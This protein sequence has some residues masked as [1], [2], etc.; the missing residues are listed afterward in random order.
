VSLS[1]LRCVVAALILASCAATLNGQSATTGALEGAVKDAAGAAVPNATV[2]LLNRAT[3][4][5]HTAVSDANGAFRFS[6]LPPATYQVSF[7]A[8]GFKTSLMKEL[9]VNV[10]EVPVLDA[11][12]E[13]GDASES[14]ACRCRL[15]AAAT[16]TGTLVDQKTITSVPLN[17]RNFTQVLSM[18]SG[19]AADVNNA[20]TLGRGT[21]SVFVNGN[22]TA[23]A[24]TIDG[25]YA[26]ST[27]PNPDTIAEFKIQTSQYDAMYGAMAPSTNLLTKRGENDWHGD[28][29][30]F[31]RNDAFNANEFFRKTTGQPK[32]NLKQNQFG[33]TLGSAVKKNKLFVF[34]S[35]QGT[36]QVNGLDPTSTSNLILPALGSDRSAS[37]LAA[38]F[39]PAN[40]ATTG[41][42][43]DSRYITFAGGKQ[44]DCLNRSTETTAPINP[45]ALSILQAKRGDGAY[46]IPS[47][48]TIIA[49]GANAGL[50]F[51]S[52][53]LPSTYRENH[54]IANPDYVMSSKHTLS[55]R[56]FGATIHQLRSFGSSNGYPGAP[57]VPGWGASQ[58]LEATDIATSIRLTTTLTANVVNEAAM[59][60]TRN[61]TDTVGVD[62]PDAASFGMTAVD[63]LFP[64]TPE[65]TVLGPL[66]TFRAFGTNPND[67]H[68]QTVTHS[69]TENLSW[70]RGKQRIR[71]GGIYLRQYNGRADTG[72]A[73]GK[74]TFRT[75]SDFL[76]GLSA[77]DNLSPSGLSNIQSVQASEGVGPNGE[78]QYRYRRQY[79]AAYIQDDIKPTS[80][81]TL[82][83]GLRWEYIGPSLDTAGAIGNVSPALLKT[84]AIP[85]LAGT[86]VGN[87]VAANYQPDLV[88][89][90]TG[91]TFGAPPEGVLA[92]STNSFYRNGTPLDMF[93]PRAGF[94]WQPFGGSSRV[95][96]GGGYGW[97]YQTP[98]FSGNAASAPLFTSAPF[99]QS[100]TNSDAS[101]NLSSFQ[102]P[103]SATTLGFVLRTPFSQL[104][105][106]VA[107]P[108]YKIPRLQQWNFST[109]FRL[110]QGLSFDLG[111]VG[112]YGDRLMLSRGLN[113]PML[114]SAAS[115]VN[116]G[117]DGVA[118]HCITTSTSQNAKLRVPIMGETPT[119]LLASEFAGS[120]SYHSMQATLRGQFARRLTFQAAYTFSKSLNTNAVYNDQNKL[121]LARGRAA[122]DRTHRVIANFDYQLPGLL[123]GWSA[124]G[125]VIMQSGLP[126]TLTDP[127]AGAVYGRAG[128]STIT[129]CPNATYSQLSTPGAV[130]ERL[131]RWIDASAI[132]SAPAIGS[133]GSTGYGSAG[134]SI[135]NGP[136]QVNTDFSL[137]KRAR[138]GGLRED[139][140]LAFRVEF[141]NALNHAQFSNPGAT[142]GTASFGVITQSSVAPRLI[143][144]GLKYLF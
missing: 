112:S 60:F 20:G 22:T 46:L 81:F 45:V 37:A 141:Y 94:S 18:S 42:Q 116:C 9:T 11:S 21:Q 125:I 76:L 26:P 58:V 78:V 43:P 34:G 88:N 10:S 97:F 6:L 121:P 130:R 119:A 134:Q 16:S 142:L 8:K 61:H 99:A 39:C 95:S 122:S 92:G 51:S 100:F 114:A 24:Y 75:F 40:H 41:G 93:A 108:E 53:S 74:M 19:S 35:Y 80:H 50:G 25:A 123:H 106:R 120:S 144:F 12:L 105:D 87:V 68:F 82:N 103:F 48:Q 111:Y 128:T 63:P 129:M 3:D 83:L 47:P 132:C 73:R 29:W 38:Q 79:G 66:G 86:L 91:K 85:S 135:L 136:G 104:S 4:Q 56:F 109:K 36:R 72:G 14:V 71:M 13:S 32:P 17:T 98:L 23:G 57:V 62:T 15:A 89:P 31:L 126:M 27:V 84:A 69:W 67:N 131:G 30:E 127:G 2:R 70:A 49:S 44:L 1:R 33:M 113:Q 54:F 107:G 143:Q 7:S 117:Y 90:Y 115:P 133:D 52:Y 140:E 110:S 138:V 124:A 96:V 102:R 118:G 77:A 137:G 55:G 64:K 5:A 139:A 59:A 65:V 28:L 101:N